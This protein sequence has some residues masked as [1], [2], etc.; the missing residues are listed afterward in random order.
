LAARRSILQGFPVN[1][2]PTDSAPRRD[3]RARGI[4]ARGVQIGAVFLVL[5]I[6]LFAAAGDLAWTWGWVYIAIYLAS[7][8]VNAG[9]LLRRD[10]DLVAERGRP[11][12]MPRWDKILGGSWSLVQFVLLPLVAGL[13]ARFALTGPVEVVWH[14]AG[15]LVFAA[16]LALFGWAMIAN[17]YFSTVARIQPERGQTVCREGPYRFVRHPG[18]S[19]A[20]LQSIGAP[21]LLGSLWALVPAL[22]AGALMA[23]RT[24]FEDRM[25]RA[26][27]SG[28]DEYARY[29]RRRLVPGVW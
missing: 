3:G 21:L 7:T 18:Y 17:A 25:L 19:G 24:W 28:Y 26:E 27:L 8:I 13:D 16:G 9:F 2:Q 29:V 14:L 6:V 15:A 12:P 10:P 11:G 5:G 20:I 1:A 4:A 22:A 23:A